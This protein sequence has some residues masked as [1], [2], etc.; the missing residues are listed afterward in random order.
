M[1]CEINALAL[2]NMLKWFETMG[3]LERKEDW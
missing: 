3:E 1:E 2:M